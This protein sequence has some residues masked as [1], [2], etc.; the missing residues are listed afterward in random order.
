MA[1]ISSCLTGDIFVSKPERSIAVNAAALK[2]QCIVRIHQ[3]KQKLHHKL[4]RRFVKVYDSVNDEYV[5]KDKQSGYIHLSKPLLLGHGDIQTPRAVAGPDDYD[6]KYFVA[7]RDGHAIIIT[8]S[9]FAYNDV[10]PDL[11]IETVAEHIKLR[12]VLSHDF[13]CQLPL[14]SIMSL[15]IG[16]AHV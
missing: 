1:N 13:I 16:R 4:R 2:I 5:Y 9:S 11:P 15:Q 10:I 3:S 8:V 12:D 7:H 14:Q 6:P